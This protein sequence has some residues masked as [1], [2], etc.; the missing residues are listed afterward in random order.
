LEKL[1][2]GQ[3]TAVFTRKK[4]LNPNLNPGTS[5]VGIRIP[6]HDIIRELVRKCPTPIALTSANRSGREST[7]EIKV[8]NVLVQFVYASKLMSTVCFECL[9]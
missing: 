2:P 3:L 4:D 5:L 1:F 8:I 7:L 9:F 6:G